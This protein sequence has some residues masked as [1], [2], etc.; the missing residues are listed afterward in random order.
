MQP[1]HMADMDHLLG[2][3]LNGLDFLTAGTPNATPHAVSCHSASLQSQESMGTAHIQQSSQL[4]AEAVSATEAHHSPSQ[5]PCWKLLR[6]HILK[7][8]RHSKLFLAT[9][10]TAAFLHLTTRNC[11]HSH[12][13]L[14]KEWW[15]GASSHFSLERRSCSSE[16]EG[17]PRKRYTRTKLR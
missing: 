8:L 1:N 15:K 6:R 3:D 7:S 2:I 12:H 10:R 13:W 9:R 4:E 16:T 11:S 5:K 14:F 17:W